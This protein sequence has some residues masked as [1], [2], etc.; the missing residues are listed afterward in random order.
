MFN[1]WSKCAVCGSNKANIMSMG[2]VVVSYCDDCN[3]NKRK[4]CDDVYRKIHD[5]AV[6]LYAVFPAVKC[7]QLASSVKEDYFQYL[8]MHKQEP[9]LVMIFEKIARE[10]Y[11]L[12]SEGRK[13]HWLWDGQEGYITGDPEDNFALQSVDF[14]YNRLQTYDPGRGTAL[15][16]FVAACCGIFQKAKLKNW[17]DWA[18]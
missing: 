6:Q 8:V 3:K 9:E 11:K 4:E 7:E 1:D 13:C 10:V 16:Y 5:E 2:Y 12:K 15:D 17:R 14:C 18:Y